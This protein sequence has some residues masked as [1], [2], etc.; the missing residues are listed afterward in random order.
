SAVNAEPVIKQTSAVDAEPVIKQTSIVNAE[1]ILKQTSAVNAETALMHTSAVDAEPVIK[2]TND[3]E[4][5]S[6]E[7]E[8]IPALIAEPVKETTQPEI[9]KHIELTIVET[10]ERPPETPA[11]YGIDPD[12][13]IPGISRPKI[14]EIHPEPIN[15]PDSATILTPPSA[16]QSVSPQ[17]PPLAKT[18]PPPYISR[19]DSGSFYVQIASLKERDLVESALNRINVEYG[20]YQPVVFK[21]EGSWYRIL[22]GPLN[23]G[24][25]GA[26]LRRFKSI[27]YKDSFIRQGK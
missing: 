17:T 27:G 24:E 21:D 1:P 8:H 13:I 23:Q 9:G 26:I 6:A 10:E 5:K 7:P 14:A 12:Y 2:Q 18:Y 25:S 19:L 11:I 20:D 15:I 4:E 3:I 16:L 22:L